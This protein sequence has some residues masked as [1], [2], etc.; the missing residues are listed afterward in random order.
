MTIFHKIVNKEVPAYIIAENDTHIAFLDIFPTHLGQTV[1]I[2]KEHT[3]SHF[4]KA[5]TTK[6]LSTIE[7]AQKVTQQIEAKLPG[8]IRCEIIIEGF[9]V[10][11]LHIK[12]IPVRQVP[13]EVVHHGGARADDAVLQQLQSQLVD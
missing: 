1:V 6:L 11:Y 10:D 8:V 7:F 12:V 3:T 5:D 9:E 2:P 4:A 13:E